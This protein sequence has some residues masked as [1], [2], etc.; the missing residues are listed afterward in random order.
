[1]DILRFNFGLFIFQILKSRFVWLYNNNN[2]GD[3]KKTFSAFL[4]RF[5]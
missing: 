2:D 5:L 3:K 4:G 1:M